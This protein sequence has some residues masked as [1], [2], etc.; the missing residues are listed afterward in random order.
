ML[1][2]RGKGSI[3]SHFFDFELGTGEVGACNP[4][5]SQLHSFEATI[6]GNFLQ[7]NSLKELWLMFLNN[8]KLFFLQD[9][10]VPVIN[11]EKQSLLFFFECLTSFS[12]LLKD[13]FLKV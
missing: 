9:F 8:E 2:F 12:L 7:S 13:C 1:R 3:N 4:I 10:K 11:F 5:E 6:D